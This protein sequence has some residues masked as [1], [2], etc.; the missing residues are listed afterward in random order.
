[1]HFEADAVQDNYDRIKSHK[2][3]ATGF[4]PLCHK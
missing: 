3:Q 4:G 2:R 1:M